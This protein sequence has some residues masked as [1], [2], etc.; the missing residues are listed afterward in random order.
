MKIHTPKIDIGEIDDI[1]GL[2]HEEIVKHGPEAKLKHLAGEIT[3][4]Q[5]EW[6]TQHKEYMEQL[7]DK[8]KI[9]LLEHKIA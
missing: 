6:H 2:L 1:L 8:L 5:L 9:I 3:T 4:S 7:S